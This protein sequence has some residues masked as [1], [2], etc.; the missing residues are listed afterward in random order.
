MSGRRVVVGWWQ[1][2][3]SGWVPDEVVG[4]S[5]TRRPQQQHAMVSAAE[6]Q[7]IIVP[8]SSSPSPTTWPPVEAPARQSQPTSCTGKESG[9]CRTAT[10]IERH[11][12][13]KMGMGRPGLGLRLGPVGPKANFIGHRST[14]LKNVNYLIISMDILDRPKL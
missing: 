7:C 8:Y 2:P 3:R 9:P 5:S 6:H 11:G 4:P 13:L 14:H 1:R 12:R 10:V